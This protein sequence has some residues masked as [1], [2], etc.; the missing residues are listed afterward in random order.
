MGQI[1]FLTDALHAET[2]TCLKG[3]EFTA[4]VGF[5]SII[6]ETDSTMLASALLSNEL[7]TARI[8]VLFREAKFLLF[9]SFIEFKVHVCK[10]VCNSVAHLL[11]THGVHMSEGGTMYWHDV[12][13]GIVSSVVA[14]DLAASAFVC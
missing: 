12:V 9:T 2:I 10:R 14:I 13:P 3:I 7:D 4:V 6:I 5:G 1:H 11:A 8:G